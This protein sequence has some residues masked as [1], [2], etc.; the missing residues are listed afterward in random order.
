[1]DKELTKA[2]VYQPFPPRE[3]G[4]F[5]GVGGLENY[6][7]THEEADIRGITKDCAEEIVKVCNDLPHFAK[8]FISKIRHVIDN[9]RNAIFDCGCRF[10]NEFSNSVSLCEECSKL[11][12]HNR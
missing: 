10:T 8:D 3:D 9:D 7:L 1:M 5:Y 2:Y 11:P 4:R 6:G 12:C